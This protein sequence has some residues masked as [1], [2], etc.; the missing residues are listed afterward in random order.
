MPKRVLRMAIECDDFR[1]EDEFIA[2]DLDD[3]FDLILGMPWLRRYQPSIDWKKK[4]ISVD[5]QVDEDLGCVRVDQR[6]K[7]VAKVKLQL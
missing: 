5:K 1:G 3:K 4:K 2:L 7:I 6:R